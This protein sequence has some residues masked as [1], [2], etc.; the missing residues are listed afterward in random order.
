[1]NG[2]I[3]CQGLSKR[4]NEVQALHP[5][6]L[7]IP[8][9]SIFGFLGRN[10]AGKTTTIRL[11]T[12]L[13]R[14]TSGQA[15]V[16]GIE[17]T[18]SDSAARANFGYLPQNPAF[19]NWMTPTMYLG[20]I[21][22]LFEMPKHQKKQRI[23]EMLAL[24]GLQEAANRKIQGFSGGMMQRLGIAQAMLHQPPVLFLDEPTSALD[25]NGRYELLSLIESLR[26]EVTVFL[27]SHILGDIERVCDTI[28]IVQDGRL[29]TVDGRDALLARYDAN[30]VSLTVTEESVE[31]LE[32]F[33]KMLTA[34]SWVMAAS[35]QAAKL[36]IH[37]NDTAVA[38]QALLPLV[39]Q[40]NLTLLKYEWVRPS[41]EDIFLNIQGN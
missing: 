41:L 8:G 38:Q 29:I 18:R 4:Y 2:T 33:M 34:H 6:D 17:T 5:L 11:L 26:G 39:V 21:A 36:S 10:G 9:G 3:R 28:G 20:Y 7:E 30:T 13:A 1:M 15:W 37:V 24:A 32:P 40:H 23:T 19:Y 35:H 12:G 22:D 27:S 25:P 31:H 14:P 16:A